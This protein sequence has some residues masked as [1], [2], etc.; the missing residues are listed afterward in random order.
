V[1]RDYN[2]IL[3]TLDREERHPTPHPTSTLTSTL[4]PTLAPTPRQ[5]V[6][7]SNK[8]LTTNLTLDREE[9]NPTPH[10]TSTLTFTLTQ[11]ILQPLSQPSPQPRGRW[12]ATTT[13]S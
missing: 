8:I 1:V 6:R 2:K 10:L 11:K 7:D 13:R 12:C 9:R 3:T 4:T 5:V